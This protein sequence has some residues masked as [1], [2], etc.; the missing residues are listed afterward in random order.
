MPKTEAYFMY[1]LP[2]KPAFKGVIAWVLI[3]GAILR[4]FE[5]I[6]LETFNLRYFELDYTMIDS[7]IN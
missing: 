7:E 2:Y 4:Y 1:I 5:F 3:V 6:C